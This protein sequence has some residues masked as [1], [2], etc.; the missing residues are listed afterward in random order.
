MDLI[1]Q[2]ER[3]ALEME[4]CKGQGM[5]SSK[6]AEEMELRTWG[7]MGTLASGEA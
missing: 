1:G 7:D 6:G 4:Q 5:G 2:R 3:K